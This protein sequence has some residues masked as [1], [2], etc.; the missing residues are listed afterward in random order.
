MITVLV[1]GGRDFHDWFKLTT[2]LD[3]FCQERGVDEAQQ[4]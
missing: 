4:T 1:C 2:T 3:N